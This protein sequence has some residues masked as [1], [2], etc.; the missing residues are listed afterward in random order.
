MIM[1]TPPARPARSFSFEGS[2]PHAVRP[3]RTRSSWRSVSCRCWTKISEISS[4]PAILGARRIWTSA[5][6]SIE[7]TSVRYLTSWSERSRSAILPPSS[8]QP[9]RLRLEED[10]DR[11]VRLALEHRVGLRRLV[12][13]QLVGREVL[14]SQRI[15]VL[16]QERQDL[17]RPS[18]DVGLSHEDLDLLV[19]EVHHRHRV[20]SSAVDP[21]DREGPASPNG[22][23]GVV[24]GAHAVD[25]GLLDQP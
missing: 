21:G 25:P 22:V 7:W 23:D 6:S 13:R 15:S 11:A 12:Q 8:R 19:E 5:C 2:P 10:L 17:V 24:E 20:E 1:P 14:G 16:G 4:S 18:S 9:A 3:S